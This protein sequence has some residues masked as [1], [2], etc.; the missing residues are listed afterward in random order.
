MS[1]QILAGVWIISHN[2]RSTGDLPMTGCI[3]LL[4]ICAQKPGTL[5][6]YNPNCTETFPFFHCTVLDANHVFTS[7]STCVVCTSYCFLI[8]KS[9]IG[10]VWI[11]LQANLNVNSVWA[12]TRARVP[13]TVFAILSFI[14]TCVTVSELFYAHDALYRVSLLYTTLLLAVS[15]YVLLSTIRTLLCIQCNNLIKMPA[16]M[17]TNF[18]PCNAKT[19]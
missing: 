7:Q 6:D 12:P 17:W 3:V 10:L 4:S 8:L 14:H 9:L 2:V 19:G 18:A 15:S 1:T 16:Y 5:F 11:I 13:R